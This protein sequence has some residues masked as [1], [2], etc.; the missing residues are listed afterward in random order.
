[1]IRLI[2]ADDHA[3]LRS[4]LKRIFAL[5]T[6]MEVVGE[7]ENG[8]EV[9]S[10]VQQVEVDLLLLDLNMPGID[11]V[12]LIQRVR[13]HRKGLPILILSMHNEP[14]VATRALHAGADGYITK[15]C[16]TDVLLLAIRKVASGG[17]FIAPNLAEKIVFGAKAVGADRKLTHLQG[18]C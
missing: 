9:L 7:A 12:E 4:G 8:S 13:A 3:I 18:V 17:Q 5:V 2:I 11:G 1:M 16:E 15:D 10:Q 6:D 14:Q